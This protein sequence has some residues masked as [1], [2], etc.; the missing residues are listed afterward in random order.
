M[1]YPTS[2]ANFKYLGQISN[3]YRLMLDI[4]KNTS[5]ENYERAVKITNNDL[6]TIFRNCYNILIEY[7]MFN[8]FIQHNKCFELFFNLNEED[9]TLEIEQ[10]RV[11]FTREIISCC[12][13]YESE[14]KYKLKIDQ[15]KKNLYEK[16][17]ECI[18][19]FNIIEKNKMKSKDIFVEYKII[20]ELKEQYNSSYIKDK[21]KFE[22]ILFI[23]YFTPDKIKYL[24]NLIL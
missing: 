9:I 2:Y 11:K 18:N 14:K 20:L 21:N 7:D 13:S 10:N 17:F 3:E 24:E 5:L 16:E 12:L 15:E 4:N 23:K 1:S 22:N 8:E 6:V 19:I